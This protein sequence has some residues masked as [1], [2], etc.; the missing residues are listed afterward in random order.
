MARGSKFFPPNVN[1]NFLCLL[2]HHHYSLLLTMLLLTFLCNTTS[3]LTNY[4]RH[5]TAARYK[6]ITYPFT[7][8][9]YDSSICNRWNCPNLHRILKPLFLSNNISR[10]SLHT[11]TN[12][13]TTSRTKQL[14]LNWED[15]FGGYR[16][17]GSVGCFTLVVVPLSMPR[18]IECYGL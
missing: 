1:D 18:R 6:K 4:H 14:V 3:I 5:P 8:S 12:N 16:N 13:L 7:K 11:F 10:S 2:G 15:S 17:P 9:S